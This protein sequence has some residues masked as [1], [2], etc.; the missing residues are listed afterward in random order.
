[1]KDNLN[2]QEIAERLKSFISELWN[3]TPSSFA[4][5]VGINPGN[6]GRML[7][8]QQTIT[9]RTLNKISENFHLNIEWLRTGEGEPWKEGWG[10]ETNWEEAAQE[11][12]LEIYSLNNTV[13]WLMDTINEKDAEI[14]RKDELIQS[15]YERLLDKNGEIK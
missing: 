1:M 2:S 6:F 5:A 9:I 10:P 3:Y 13:E 4:S 11:Q 12:Q 7:K 8:G 14:K 15:L